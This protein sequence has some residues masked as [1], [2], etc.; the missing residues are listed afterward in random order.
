M[1]ADRIFKKK[2][3]SNPQSLPNLSI[4]TELVSNFSQSLT[5]TLCKKIAQAVEDWYLMP[6]GNSKKNSMILNKLHHAS[7]KQ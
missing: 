5:R 4:L 7:V 3:I 2:H 6:Y 1:R